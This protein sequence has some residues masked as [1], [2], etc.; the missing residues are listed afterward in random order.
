[1]KRYARMYVLVAPEDCDPP[2]G[3]DLGAAR[4]STKVARLV[5]AFSGFGFDPT[6][7]ALVGYPL[8]GRIQLVTGTHRHCAAGLAKILLPV[9]IIMR[10]EVEATW[11]TD[12]WTQ[13]IRDIPVR[14]LECVEVPEGVHDPLP[15]PV[16]MQEIPA[17]VED[18]A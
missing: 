11:G 4:D 7:P 6:E 10:S 5:T 8:N 18:P 3:L 13:T 12:L 16:N 17:R 9:R 2:H 14:D 1:M 15:E